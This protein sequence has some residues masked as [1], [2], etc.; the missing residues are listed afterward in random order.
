MRKRSSAALAA[1]AAILGVI[2][3]APNASAEPSPPDCPTGNV[4]AWNSSATNSPTILRT[5]GNWSGSLKVGFI[6][7]NGFS[8]PGSDHIQATWVFDGGTYNRCLHFNPGPGE[9][10]LAFGPQGVEL[11][12][13]TWRGEC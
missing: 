12:S 7:N 13:L 8:S 9:Y 11:K 3:I 5:E 2:A 1:S 10:K 4:C 6:M